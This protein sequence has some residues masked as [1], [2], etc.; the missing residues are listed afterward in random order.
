[1]DIS[2]PNCGSQEVFRAVHVHLFIVQIKVEYYH[3]AKWMFNNYIDIIVR[4]M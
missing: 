1:M 3:Q 4:S 2:N